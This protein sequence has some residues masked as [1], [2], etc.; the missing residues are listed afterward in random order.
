MAKF[1]KGQIANPLGGAAHD[2]LKRELKR[3][4]N[5]M[6]CDVI[7][8]LLRG[9]LE[10]LSLIANDTSAPALKV[11]VA[12]AIFNAA[13]TGDWSTLEKIIE[14]IVGKLPDKVEVTGTA[15]QQVIVNLPSNGREVRS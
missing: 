11:G 14:R 8:A 12:R 15:M 7:D 1:V 2:P 13:K 5:V 9:N 3:I 4:T 6:F 10:A